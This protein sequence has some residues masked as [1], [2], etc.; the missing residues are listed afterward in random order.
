VSGRTLDGQPLSLRKLAGSG[1]V[2]IDVWASWCTS[3]HEEW[4]ALA[5]VATQMN[6]SPVHSLAIDEQDPASAARAFLADT[7]ITYPQVADPR[8]DLLGTLSLLPTSGIPS[9]L[10]LDARGRMAARVIGPVT[11]NGLRRPISSLQDGS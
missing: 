1:V 10:L 5:A 4:A 3:C 7:G 2:V 11:Q 8:G 6:G 9:T